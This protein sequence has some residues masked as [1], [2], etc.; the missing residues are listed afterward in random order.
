MKL[1]WYTLLYRHMR[2]PNPLHP[3]VWN[4]RI[5]PIVFR[6]YRESDLDAC[7]NLHDVNAPGRF[8][9]LD[10]SY[11]TT[12]ASGRMYTLVAEKDGKVI[13]AG[14][15][16]YWRPPGFLNPKAAVLSFGLVH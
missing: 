8:P 2:G 16:S 15:V 1:P 11:G 14:S 7:V 5:H 6:R 13:A 4:G 3:A 9:K 10:P 12:L